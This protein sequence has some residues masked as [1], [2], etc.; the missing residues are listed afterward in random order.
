MVGKETYNVS[1]HWLERRGVC[2][3]KEVASDALYTHWLSKVFQVT[4]IIMHI[5]YPLQPIDEDHGGATARP[6]VGFEGMVPFTWIPYK[7]EWNF[8]IVDNT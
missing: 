4:D 8:G 7:V 2:N 3:V 6:S 1:F 5:L